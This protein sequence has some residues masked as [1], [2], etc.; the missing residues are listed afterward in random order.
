M[1]IMTLDDIINASFRKANFGG[2]RPEDVDAFIDNVQESY[3]QLQKEN[4]ELLRKL[5][6]LAA[7]VEEY[8][9]Q[10]E[11]I[12]N[13]LLSAQKLADASV[14]EAKHKSEVILTDAT[15][16][17]E[18]I[19]ANAQK[20]VE[21]QQNTIEHLQKEVVSF[22]SRLL[23]IYKE[24]LT[25]IDA[26]PGAESVKEEKAAKQPDETDSALQEEAVPLDEPAQQEPAPQ[27]EITQV[28]EEKEEPA[29]ISSYSAAHEQP[30]APQSESKF[31]VLKF[32]EEYDLHEDDEE[33]PRGLFGHKK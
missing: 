12:R 33:S 29:E 26:L 15:I 11:S 3:D 18:R 20:E 32:G 14:R 28:P 25:L 13:T 1:S 9:E 4:S 8:R 17:A 6:I 22:R 10:E 2:Y 7:K 5:K 27:E 30:A 21:V 23:T 24:H 31:S 16:K 19:V